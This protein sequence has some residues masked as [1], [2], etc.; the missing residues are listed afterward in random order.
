MKAR[1]F[2]LSVAVAVALPMVIFMWTIVGMLGPDLG[3]H[4]GDL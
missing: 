2:R 1:I 4:D 3:M